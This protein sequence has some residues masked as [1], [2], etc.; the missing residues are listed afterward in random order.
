MTKLHAKRNSVYFHV[1]LF[2]IIQ[3]IFCLNISFAQQDSEEELNKQFESA[4]T[5]YDSGNLNESVTSFTKLIDSHNYNSKTTA[6]FFFK[7]KIHLELNQ[8]NQFK[9]AADQFLK[10]YPRSKYVEEVRL[11]LT[12]YYLEVANYYNAFK[13]ILY[14]I[15]ET[16]SAKYEKQAKEICEGIAYNY[17]NDV[18]LQKFYSLSSN[19]K[20]KSYIL[21]EQGKLLLRDDE[22]YRANKTF[23]EIMKEFPDSDEADE[24]EKLISFSVTPTSRSIVIG[25]MLPLETDSIGK[26]TSQPAIEILEGIKF[27]V[28]EYNENRID[29]IGLLIRDTKKDIEEIKKIRDEFV[30]LNSLIAVLGPIFSNEVRIT[31]NEFEDYNIPIISPTATDDDLTDLSKNFFQANPSFSVRGKNLAQYVFYAEDKKYMSIMS[32]IDGYSPILSASFIKEFE[33]LGGKIVKRE[34]FKNNSTD[35]SNPIS[36]IYSDSLITQGIYIPLSDNSVTPYIF[37]ELIKYYKKIPL[38]G[39]QDWLTAKGF[40]TASSS[41][42]NLIFESDYFVDFTSET[43]NNF[44]DQFVD[45]T[46]KDVNRNVLYG[47]DAAKYLLTAIKNIEPSRKNLADKM[48][49]GMV[50]NGLHNNISFDSNRVNKYLNIVRYKDGLFELVDRFKLTQ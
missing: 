30:S 29:K 24:A 48:T 2:L 6:A 17:L 39:N 25:V 41:S 35:L 10:L 40:E 26:Y 22:S 18:Q 9:S 37:S 47:Y 46:G 31:L 44:S 23:D 33:K 14:I 19:E 45:M 11:L 34:T 13:E 36:R 20:V 16:S 7:I 3:F 4:L 28:N 42:N 8:L 27:A 12:K 38:Y 21:L 50:S 1:K 15:N 5:L 43:F 49:S 32:S